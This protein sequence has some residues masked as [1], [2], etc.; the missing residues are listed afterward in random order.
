MP[1]C[2]GHLDGFLYIAITEIASGPVQ[3][4]LLLSGLYLGTFSFL[5]LCVKCEYLHD[6]ISCIGCLILFVLIKIGFELLDLVE[7]I[8]I[9]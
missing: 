2:C 5:L 6:D 9:A 3:E 8:Y 4:V 7:F 1:K